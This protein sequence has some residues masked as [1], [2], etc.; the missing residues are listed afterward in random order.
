MTNRTTME[1]SSAPQSAPEPVAGGQQSAAIK[2][3]VRKEFYLISS[4]AFWKGEK[5]E[6]RTGYEVLRNGETT[7]IR[8]SRLTGGAPDYTV[9]F[10][11]LQAP[12]GA[13]LDL[14]MATTTEVH[15]WCT[16]QVAK[17]RGESR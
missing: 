9:E 12:G 14:Q 6:Y 17:A 16:E 3:T 10:D 2:W 8:R 4:G 7:G 1:G 5:Q 15:Q 13:E 11:V